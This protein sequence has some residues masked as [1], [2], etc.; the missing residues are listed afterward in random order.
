MRQPIEGDRCKND[1]AMC[2]QPSAPRMSELACGKP[3]IAISDETERAVDVIAS[4]LVA[5]RQGSRAE[6]I[7]W[8]AIDSM[9]GRTTRARQISAA[10]SSD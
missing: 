8:D 9:R 1:V 5:V 2:A 10:D 3:N 6:R 7:R 4:A